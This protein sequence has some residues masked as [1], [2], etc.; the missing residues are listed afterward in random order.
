MQPR[1]RR[2]RLMDV[3]ARMPATTLAVE[4]D[5]LRIPVAEVEP[6]A[7]LYERLGLHV[8]RVDSRSAVVE[9][10]CGITL[11]LWARRAHGSLTPAA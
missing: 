9:L 8:R 3:E 1:K 7:G 4:R 5:I 2:Q 11:V 10:P 6:M